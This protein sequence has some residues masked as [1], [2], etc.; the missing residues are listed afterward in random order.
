MPL[1]M[2]PAVR[3]S[4]NQPETPTPPAA[5]LAG[6]HPDERSLREPAEHRL[7]RLSSA[8]LVAATCIASADE[9]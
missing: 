7:Y 1:L 5:S 3:R 4:A 2:P 8:L 6:Q 9:L